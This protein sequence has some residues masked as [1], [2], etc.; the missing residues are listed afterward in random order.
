MVT[1]SVVLISHSI[2]AIITLVL[3]LYLIKRWHFMSNYMKVCYIILIVSGLVSFIEQYKEYTAYGY[4][5]CIILSI[6][7]FFIENKKPKADDLSESKD[8][9][10]E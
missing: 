3:I 4:G 6:V 8:K 7:S 1:E 10:V 5:L 2:T 9:E